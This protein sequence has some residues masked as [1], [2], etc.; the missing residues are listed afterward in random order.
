MRLRTCSVAFF[1][2]WLSSSLSNATERPPVELIMEKVAENQDRAQE[3]RKEFVYRQNLTIRL[4]R[5]NGKLA[6]AGDL[7]LD[8]LQA[9]IAERPR[10]PQHVVARAQEI[11]QRVAAFTGKQ[12]ALALALLVKLAYFVGP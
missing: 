5:G 11:V 9:K 3:A 7:A 1:I 12:E 10:I 8:L 4:L 2:L 6:G